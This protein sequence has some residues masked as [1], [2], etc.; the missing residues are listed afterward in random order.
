MARN[1]LSGSQ[2]RDESLETQDIKNGTILL[3]DLNQEIIDLLGGGG[4]NNLSQLLDVLI[5]SPVDGDALVYNATSGKWENAVVGAAGTGGTGGSGIVNEFIYI[6]TPNGNQ[7][8]VLPLASSVDGKMYVVK[9]F[10]A[11]WKLTIT[12]TGGNLMDDSTSFVLRDYESLT[13]KSYNGNWYI[14]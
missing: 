14:V 4:V 9:K 2:I 12:V 5:P 8:Y 1:Q 7:T 3:E 13:L 6:P 10:G 11:N